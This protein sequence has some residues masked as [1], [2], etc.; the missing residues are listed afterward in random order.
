M[1]ANL[2]TNLELQVTINH[3]DDVVFQE[4]KT[5]PSLWQG[6]KDSLIMDGYFVPK[7]K[8][9]Y[10]IQYQWSQD[11]EEYL[12][13]DNEKTISFHVSDSANNR[14]GDQPD[15]MY[16]N[17]SGQARP[18]WMNGV[19]MPMSIISWGLCFPFMKTVKSTDS[20]PI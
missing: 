12:P 8:G 17:G 19:F 4:S 18:G 7:E 15:F 1:G 20:Q 6:Y 9:S 14:A 10:T 2:A 5:M 13:E 3:D 16:I 11:N